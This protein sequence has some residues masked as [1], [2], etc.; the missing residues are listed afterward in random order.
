MKNVEKKAEAEIDHEPPLLT[1]LT[2]SAKAEGKATAE[3]LTKIFGAEA[4]EVNEEREGADSLLIKE[5]LLSS[6]EKASLE[7]LNE[8][9]DAHEITL[10]M[11][12]EDDNPSFILKLEGLP[13]QAIIKDGSFWRLGPLTYGELDSAVHDIKHVMHGLITALGRE[14]SYLDGKTNFQ[15]GLDG[16]PVFNSK[17][18]AE[19]W[20]R[21]VAGYL[22]P[23]YPKA[24]SDAFMV[25]L[26]QEYDKMRQTELESKARAVETPSK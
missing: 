2:D 19:F 7:A 6:D 20:G 5:I 9:C 25:Y 14:P 4:A 18:R 3:R 12:M 24:D 15:F 23:D 17:N 11:L 10:Q 16:R 1:K 13:D 21:R 26:N 8:Y 22:R